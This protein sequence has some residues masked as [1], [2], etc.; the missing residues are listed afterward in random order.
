ME[1]GSVGTR[2]HRRCRDPRDLARALSAKMFLRVSV[3]RTF[4]IGTYSNVSCQLGIIPGIW[5]ALWS[6]NTIEPI[7]FVLR[8]KVMEKHD[9]ENT[10]S[11]TA[12]SP[13]GHS[14]PFPSLWNLSLR[15]SGISLNFACLRISSGGCYFNRMIR[16]L[17]PRSML[18]KDWI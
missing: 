1:G 11:D 2:E 18:N 13:C 6:G 3:L 17:I 7:S 15:F 8:R 10:V 16:Q 9:F 5:K 4:Y 14:K 12:R